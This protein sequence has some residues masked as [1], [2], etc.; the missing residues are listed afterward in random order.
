MALMTHPAPVDLLEA[1]RRIQ[2][3]FNTKGFETKALE[4]S[5]AYCIRARKTSTLRA[6]MAADRALEVALRIS[7]GQTEI[8]VRQGSWQTNFVSNAVWL[9][10]TGGMNL[11][12]TGWSI[13]LQKELEAHIRGVL[14]GLTG[15]REIDLNAAFRPGSRVMVSA[16]DGNRYPATVT[17]AAQGKY[18]CTMPDG[19]SYWIP[20][21]NV[22]AAE[23]SQ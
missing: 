23:E 14:Q 3:W 21:A 6:V 10:A 16:P 12:F 17:Q 5:G 8:D 1:A 19:K 22:G 13:V 20:Y 9:V 4:H 15:A 2:W 7:N 11:V 18:E